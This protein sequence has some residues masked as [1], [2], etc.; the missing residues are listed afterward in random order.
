MENHE[1][2]QPAT[3]R[4]NLFLWGGIALGLLLVLLL[5]TRGFGLWAHG[6]GHPEKP[7]L[8]HENGRIF[9]PADSPLRGR[10]T[11]EIGR[12]HV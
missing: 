6:G 9:V 5:I 8:V 3:A 10:L 11:V 1:Y 12:A 7:Q 4:A 2:D